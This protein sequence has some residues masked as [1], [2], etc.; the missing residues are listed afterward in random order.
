MHSV[1]RNPGKLS[2]GIDQP[3]KIDGTRGECPMN[4]IQELTLHYRGW[5]ICGTLRTDE[6][7]IV[8]RKLGGVDTITLCRKHLSLAGRGKIPQGPALGFPS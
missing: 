3:S 2:E 4:E 5:V 1:P 7:H 6:H 8:K